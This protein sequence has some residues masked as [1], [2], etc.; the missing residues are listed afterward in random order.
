MA[1]ER[2]LE[3]KTGK[4]QRNRKYLDKKADPANPY[5]PSIKLTIFHTVQS[6]CVLLIVKTQS[7]PSKTF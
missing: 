6:T 1:N 7:F 2:V 5:A 4:V 3:R